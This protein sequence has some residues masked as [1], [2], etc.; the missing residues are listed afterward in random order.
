MT[1]L[2]LNFELP[3]QTTMNRKCYLPLLLGLLC[4]QFIAAQ[5]RFPQ[6]VNNQ[7]N[8]YLLANIQEKL[9]LQTNSNNY[10]AGDTV[11]F[12]TTLVNAVTHTPVGN[13]LMYY[14]DLISPENKVVCHQVF[15]FE[16][17]FSGAYLALN[18]QLAAG[19]YKILAYTNYMRNFPDEFMF[20]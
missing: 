16:G 7:L 11:W 19:T 4:F 12:K 5:G 20:Q 8:R 3:N 1:S 14:V 13:E 6:Q 2:K 18:K 15:A 9:Y 10:L 17:G